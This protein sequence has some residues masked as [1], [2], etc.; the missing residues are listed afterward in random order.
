MNLPVINPFS[1]Q[2]IGF[3]LLA[4]GTSGMEGAAGAAWPATKLALYMPFYVPDEFRVQQIRIAQGLTI[5]GN[6]DVGVY[7]ADGVRLASSGLTA[8]TGFS[9]TTQGVT[10]S[11][12]LGQGLYYMAMSV[13]NVT[14]TVVRSVPT[15]LTLQGAGCAQ[16][17]LSAGTGA[18]PATATFAAI[19][20][21]YLPLFGLSSRSF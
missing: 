21:A 2:S 9:A 7:T 17:D 6:F 19:A 14:H 4:V 16:E 8:P 3:S 10:V 12:R 11:T 15:A 20:N 5:S 13:D 18:L 1:L